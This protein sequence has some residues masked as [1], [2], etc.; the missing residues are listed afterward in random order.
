MFAIGFVLLRI[1][2]PANKSKTLNDVAITSPFTTMVE[3]FTWSFCPIMLA[4]GQAWVVIGVFS[5]GIVV[6]LV[7][8]YATRQWFFKKPLKGRGTFD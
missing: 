5:L 8:N 2:D 3:I 6:P 1:V 4:T 7:F